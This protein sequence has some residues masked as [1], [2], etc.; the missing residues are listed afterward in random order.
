MNKKENRRKHTGFS[1]KWK[2]E[3]MLE[4]FFLLFLLVYYFMWARIQPLGAAPDESMRYSVAEYI[5]QHWELPAGDNPEIRN[6][7]WGTSYGFSPIL[8]YMISAVFMAAV[9]V[10]KDSAFALVLAARMVSVLFGVGTAFFT[11]RSAKKLFPAPKAWLMTIFVAMLP[12][13]VFVTSYVNT[14]AMAVFS[15]AVIVHAWICGLERDWDYK[16]CLELAVGISFCALSYYNAYGFILCSIFFFG[17]TLLMISSRKKDAGFFVKRG[18]V[19]CV[20]VLLLIGWWFIRNAVLYDGDIFGRT[21]SALCAEKYAQAGFKPSEHV[22]PQN[23]G[24]SFFEM[25]RKGYD[26]P[27]SWVE[28]VSRSFIGRFGMFNVILP[29]WIENNMIDFIK[30]GVI[31]VLLHPIKTFALKTKE[32]ISRKGIFNW[33]MLAAMIIP[34]LLSAWY[35]YS[36]DYQPQGRYS[37]PMLVP[38]AYFMITGYGYVFDEVI[39]DEKIRRAVY[40]GLGLVLILVSIFVYLRVFWP[41]YMQEPFGLGALLRGAE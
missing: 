16:S 14:D 18:T 40:Y 23:S 15:T 28:L 24:M 5:Y 35:S 9:S 41:V 29:T 2:K 3:T 4:I 11:L 1:V 36:S 13:A 39:R 31:L 8:S 37:L 6:A 25:L 33:C 22:T 7:I 20:V 19:V 26:T 17:C 21:A 10:V 32:G 34:N 30:V 12:G 27:F 38:L